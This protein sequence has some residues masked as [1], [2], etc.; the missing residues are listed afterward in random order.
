AERRTLKSFGVR[1]GAHSV[2]LPALMRGRAPA[3][4]Q[5]FV[6]NEAFGPAPG[7]AALRDPPPSA[8]VLAAYGLR[9]VGRLAAGVE[10]LEA[11]AERR[12]RIKG[13]LTETDLAELGISPEQGKTLA[14]GLKATRAQQPARPRK[15]AA[16]PTDS[17]FAALSA[18]ASPAPAPAR[19]KRS[20]PRRKPA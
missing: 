13:A 14:A 1:L 9:P 16:P 6:A 5:A 10:F 3:V 8:R 12:A 19:R 15:P 20:R 4:A 18:L 17:P 2:W 11:M 7:V